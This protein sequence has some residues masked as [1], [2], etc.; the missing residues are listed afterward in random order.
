MALK[1][2]HQNIEFGIGDVVRVH[3]KIVE[4]GKKER[5]QIFEGTVIAIKNRDEGKSFT[6]RRIGAQKIGIEMIFPVSSPLLTKVE[7][8]RKGMQGTKHAKLYFI[9]NKSKREIEKIYS[10]AA[11]K[12]IQ[13][14]QVKP[15]SKVVKKTSNKAVKK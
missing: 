4:E 2:I 5:V 3:Q 15:K 11:K 9:R 7:L 6:V 10:R 8:K 13:N 14:N 1:L 12:N